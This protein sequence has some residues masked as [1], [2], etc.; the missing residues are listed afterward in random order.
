VRNIRA[1][2][3]R[4]DSDSAQED[5]TQAGNKD[6]RWSAQGGEHI[7]RMQKGF[8]KERPRVEDTGTHF[9]TK[10]SDCGDVIWRCL[11]GLL[12]VWEA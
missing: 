8:K 12:L 6:I 4:S 1:N 7:K 9:D 3:V 5:R 2:G 11:F 10:I